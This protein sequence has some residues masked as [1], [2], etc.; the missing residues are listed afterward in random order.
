MQSFLGSRVIIELLRQELPYFQ[1]VTSA[2][3]LEPTFNSSQKVVF[4]SYVTNCFFDDNSRPRDIDTMCK[5]SAHIPPC[6]IAYLTQICTYIWCPGMFKC[7]HTY[8]LPMS[9]IC[10][11]HQ[12]CPNGEDELYCSN[13]ICPGLLKCRGENRC[14][15]TSEI[16]DGQVNCQYSFG[17]EI[18]CEQCPIRCICQYYFMS[19]AEIKTYIA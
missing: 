5:M 2:Y 7:N 10:N 13:L 14:V 11:G 17:D 1:N 18:M 12:E 6:K 15:S 4:P 8:C 19:C 9:V 16:C 3:Q